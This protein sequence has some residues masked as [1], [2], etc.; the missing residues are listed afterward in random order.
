MNKC[1]IAILTDS[2]G[3]DRPKYLLQTV[4]YLMKGTYMPKHLI[5]VQIFCDGISSEII[6]AIK[7]SVDKLSEADINVL[8]TVFTKEPVGC[9]HMVNTIWEMTK[10]YPYTLFLEG[11]WIL[12][13][14]L[15][16]HWLLYLLDKMDGNQVI[17][18]CFLRQYLAPTEWRQ[19]NGV[20][21]LHNPVSFVADTNLQGFDKAAMILERQIYSNNPHLRRNSSYQDILPLDVDEDKPDVKGSDNWCKP[22]E[23]AEERLRSKT[24]LYPRYGIFAHA[25]FIEQTGYMP[26]GT[27]E[28]E[29]CEDGFCRYRFMVPDP[30]WCN[31]CQNQDKSIYQIEKDFLKFVSERDGIDVTGMLK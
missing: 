29:H 2:I 13:V 6:K 27:A 21:I 19:F 7:E 8:D 4:E 20:T 25:E 16:R 23:S 22:E 1:I 17:D 11:D 24:V 9:G 14:Q 15:D 31:Q 12:N 30:D 18:T 5:D 28:C 3:E 10:D 26:G